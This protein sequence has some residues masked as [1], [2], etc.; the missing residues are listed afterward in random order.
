MRSKKVNYL[1]HFLLTEKL[2]GTLLNKSR[3]PRVVQVSSSFHF[4]VDGSDL[5]LSPTVTTTTAAAAAATTANANE[6]GAAARPV[7]SVPGGSHGFYFYRSQRQYANSKLAQILHARYLS[8]TERR[9]RVVEG[10]RWQRRNGNDNF[11]DV[12]D[13]GPDDDDNESNNHSRPNGGGGGGGSSSSH[14]AGARFVSACPAWV[15]T[16]ITRLDEGGLPAR[17]F[18]VLAFR[19]DGYGLSSILRAM[20][21]SPPAQVEAEAN[22]G[23]DSGDNDDDDDN[24]GGGRGAAATDRDYYVNTGFAHAGRYLDGFLVDYNAVRTAGGTAANTT[25]VTTTWTYRWIPVRDFA[26]S[27]VG[28]FLLQ[29]QRVWPVLDT[30]ESSRASYDERLQQE[31]YD[32]SYWAVQQWL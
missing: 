18:R 32:W 14:V 6:D 4:A 27:M 30:A 3:W 17:L 23:D 25:T 31:L 7:A 1:S 28:L 9:D 29:W 22:G 24:D 26:F 20:F 13:D 21:E 8:S 16:S 19:A 2:L 12:N 5:I 11:N 10:R 15:G